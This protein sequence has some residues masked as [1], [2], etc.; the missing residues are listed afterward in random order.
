MAATVRTK[1]GN[2]FK[3]VWGTSGCTVTFSPSMRAFL[4]LSLG[5]EPSSHTEAFAKSPLNK[6]IDGQTSDTI[7]NG[8]I[9]ALIIAW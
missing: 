8:I 6:L 7:G 3:S 4:R 2:V 1:G 9:W 5:K